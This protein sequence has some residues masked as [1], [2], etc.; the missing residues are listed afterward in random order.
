MHG[1]KKRLQGLHEDYSDCRKITEIT[2]IRQRLQR[3]RKHYNTKITETLQ[4][5]TK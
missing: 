3:L 5:I 4:N 2:V 1:G